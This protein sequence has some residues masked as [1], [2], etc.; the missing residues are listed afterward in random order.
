MFLALSLTDTVKI[1]EQWISDQKLL[2]RLLLTFEHSRRVLQL[3]AVV[4]KCV[5]Y[6]ITSVSTYC[7]STKLSSEAQNV[8]TCICSS[9]VIKGFPG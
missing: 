9:A 7:A 5:W 1:I 4:K 6:F 3:G 8:L 2:C